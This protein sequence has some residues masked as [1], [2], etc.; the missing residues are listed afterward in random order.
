MDYILNVSPNDKY[1]FVVGG[2]LTGLDTDDT[3]AEALDDRAYLD[4]PHADAAYAYIEAVES[5]THAPTTQPPLTE[6]TELS[7]DH[8]TVCEDPRLVEAMA[9]YFHGIDPSDD[10]AKNRAK[11]RLL[12]VEVYANAQIAARAEL[13]ASDTVRGHE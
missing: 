12:D 9:T 1:R 7:W 4:L 3:D 5:P 10:T 6:R 11:L 8:L 2:E 13:D